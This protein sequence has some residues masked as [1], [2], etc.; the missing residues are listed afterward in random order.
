MVAIHEIRNVGNIGSFRRLSAE[1]TAVAGGAGDA[2]TTT[3]VTIDR[4]AIPGYMG[5]LAPALVLGIAWDAVL[6]TGKTLSIGYA[7]QDSADGSNWSDY[8]TATYA[9]VGTGSTAASVLAGEIEIPV[10]L[11]SARRYVRANHAMDLSAT[12]TDTASSR[13]VGLFVRPG[14]A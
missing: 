11:G 14:R 12:G 2:S 3:G 1:A 10:R 13:S 9:I 4:M 8:Q 6:A 5:A 7:V